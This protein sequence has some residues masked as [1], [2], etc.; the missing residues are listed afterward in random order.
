MAKI[1]KIKKSKKPS[2]KRKKGRIHGDPMVE[3]SC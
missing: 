1:K 3:L 2:N